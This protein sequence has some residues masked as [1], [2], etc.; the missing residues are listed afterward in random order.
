M[1]RPLSTEF[2]RSPLPPRHGQRGKHHVSPTA[3]ALPW[4]K[5]FP[6]TQG[7]GG[8]ARSWVEDV[9]LWKQHRRQVLIRFLSPTLCWEKPRQRCMIRRTLLTP[10]PS[11]LQLW[12]KQCWTPGSDVHGHVL[13][14][15]QAPCMPLSLSCGHR[16]RADTSSPV[17]MAK[18]ETG[19]EACLGVAEQARCFTWA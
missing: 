2:T 10:R 14:R 17:S 1:Q 18:A 6:T 5:P 16:S 11:A 7:D 4:V 12:C 13:K 15:L 19:A 3:P 8:Q 9:G